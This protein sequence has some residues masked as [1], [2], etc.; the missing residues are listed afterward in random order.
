MTNNLF[1]L[2]VSWHSSEESQSR[3]SREFCFR[4][5]AV[6]NS[7]SALSRCLAD[8][9]NGAN[10]VLLD[11]SLEWNM[12]GR[13]VK[14]RYDLQLYLLS[15]LPLNLATYWCKDTLTSSVD[16]VSLN[17]L[18]QELLVERLVRGLV[19]TDVGFF[20]Y[21]CHGRSPLLTQ[22]DTSFDLWGSSSWIKSVYLSANQFLIA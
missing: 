14:S 3:I 2:Y 22:I 9:H 4:K 12:F 21:T 8:S 6:K 17:C 13:Y 5:A 18:H 7:W 19:S 1:T 15:I 16:K 10:N 20:H 11:F